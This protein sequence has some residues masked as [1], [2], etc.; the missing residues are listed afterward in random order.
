MSPWR[1]Q[2]AGGVTVRF[3]IS[4]FRD[5]GNCWCGVP[6][7]TVGTLLL[8][9]YKSSEGDGGQLWLRVLVECVHCHLLNKHTMLLLL[10]FI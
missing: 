10:L 8:F 1:R 6:S 5:I 3:R 2:C 9:Y 7:T 4:F